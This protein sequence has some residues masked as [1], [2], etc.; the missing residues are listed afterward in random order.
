M[1]GLLVIRYN[2]AKLLL[3]TDFNGKGAEKEDS[4]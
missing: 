2:P 4:C 1:R 3:R